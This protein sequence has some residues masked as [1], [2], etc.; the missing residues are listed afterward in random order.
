LFKYKLW[1]EW[2]KTCPYTN[3]EITIEDLFTDKVSIVY[4]QPWERFLNDSDNNKTLC[5]TFFKEEIASKTPYEY[6]S[7][8]PSG[9]WEKVKTR[10]LEQLLSGTAKHTSFQRFRHFVQSV[11]AQNSTTKEFDDQHV[12]A[13]KIKSILEQ[14]CPEVVASRGN[15]I[16]SIRRKWG[17][18]SPNT[19][20]NKPRHYNTREAALNAVVV[21]LNESTYLDELRYWNRYD[22]LLYRETFPTP[23]PRFTQDVLR[24]NDSIPVSVESKTNAVRI[25]AQPNG[26][27]YNLSPKGKL[28][29]DSYYGKRTSPDG[30]EAFHIRKPITSILSAKQV[31][32]I[33]DPA[34]RELVYD[35]IDLC[36]GFQNGKVPKKA[37]FASTPT[38]WETKVFLPNKR[39]D[40]V[41]VR[42]VRLQEK[43]G[44]AVQL[45]EGQNKYVNPRKN[46]HVLVYQTLD[47]VYQEDV[48]SFWEA[49][50]R[51]RT[52]EPMY[53]LPKDGRMIIATLHM[54]DCFIL[55]LNQK[56]I[57]YRLNEGLN[58]WEHVYRVQR[59]SSKYYEFKHVYDQDIYDQTYPNYV[60]ILNFGSK[61]TGWLTHKPF[62]I[63]VNILG[64]ITPFYQALKVP[65]MQ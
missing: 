9:T 57:L 24:L 63:N 48:V 8:M 61:K 43:V 5:M 28:H 39:G 6:F 20:N 49:V 4:V 3:T 47:G 44:N 7:D 15:T 40:K 62:K 41:P 22:P 38:G 12:T 13:L 35:Q 60:R 2:N 54:N 29:K 19:F 55:G 34:V 37:L 46:H 59:I 58:L 26:K 51:I 18:S 64:E 65:E 10:V 52:K 50:R 42:K 14:I 17:I 23:W 27:G 56:E 36:G 11:Y 45:S 21:G 1:Q 53:Q 32:K 33:V 25:I 16:S 31:S 30:A